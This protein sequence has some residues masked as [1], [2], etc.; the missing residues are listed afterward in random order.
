MRGRV[1]GAGQDGA[2]SWMV[3]PPARLMGLLQ[4]EMGGLGRGG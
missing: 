3:E 2:C 4:A 1:E